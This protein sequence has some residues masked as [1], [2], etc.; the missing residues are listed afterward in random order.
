V[1]TTAA[2]PHP[3][4]AT[5]PL[6][7]A[8]AALV[9]L[10]GVGA[11]VGVGHLVGGLVSPASSP[12]NAVADAAVRLAPPELVEFGKQLGPTT[13]KLVLQ[14]VVAAALVAV[15]VVAGLVSRRGPTPGR[16]LIAV[17]GLVGL[18]AV[19]TAPAF[20]PL[21]LLAPVVAVTT[22]LLVFPALHGLAQ[23]AARPGTGPAPDV[24]GVTRRA[25]LVGSSAT[26]GVGALTVGLGAL[27]AGVVGEVLGA[28][29]EDSRAEVTR[30]LAAAR[31]S[32]AP[33]IPAGADFAGLGTPTF[34]TSN[35][36]FYRVDV[37]L[38]IPTV[39]AVD[40][41][42][43]VHGMVDKELVLTFDDLFRRPLVERTITMT[44]VS[45]EVGGRYIS[46]ANFIGVELRDILLEAGVRPG[47]DQVLS[48]GA[49]GGWTAGT[50]TDVLLEP[51]RGA[52][53]AVGMNGQ[54]LPPEHGF[55][56]RMV[57]PGLYGFVSATKWLT[58]LEV[59]TFAAAQAYWRQR[60]WGTV[61]PIKT[62]SRIDHPRAFG[63]V[64]AGRVAVAGIAWSQPLGIGRVEV[65]ADGGPWRE[66]E[67]ATEVS[68]DT[69][70]MWKVDLDL[71]PGS[72]T[73]QVR[74]TDRNGVVQPEQRAEPIPDG[75]TGWH[76][77]L[78]TVA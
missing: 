24:D 4:H 54:V 14:L 45:N 32:R 25:V 8:P 47:A 20:A 56:V 77:T 51:D 65:R 17:L 49:D 11:A 13:D 60:G 22:G 40:W 50:P 9:G 18:T 78:F 2:P 66:A 42:V 59:T 76:S 64:P 30:R 5:P 55:P 41:S 52:L 29:S 74:A 75:A 48:T 68:G 33:R 12:F 67:L 58:D 34:L 27:G 28:G 15:A 39:S 26:L 21:D 44:C 57:V 61:A 43:R 38:R 31:I 72:H 7:R 37:A 16:V 19:A 1:S 73:V 3:A 36:D 53:L 6:G 23:R 63:T 71:A 46:T 70:R 35:P 62:Q 69:W 10:L